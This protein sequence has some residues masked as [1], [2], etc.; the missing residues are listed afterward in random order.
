MNLKTANA[1]GLTVSLGI[2][3]SR[4]GDQIA[5]A[6]ILVARVPIRARPSR[7]RLPSYRAGSPAAS[8]GQGCRSGGGVAGS[9]TAPA[10]RTNVRT[11]AKIL[12]RS[13]EGRNHIREGLMRTV[14]AGLF[15]AST[16]AAG[17]A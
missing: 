16:L 17:T 15:V 6:N 7:V 5:T 2:L 9:A 13:A 4:R 8:G 1:L 14:I 10:G 11:Y 12:K 3:R